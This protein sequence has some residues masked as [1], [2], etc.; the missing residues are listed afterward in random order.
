[1]DENT[2]LIDRLKRELADIDYNAQ[3]ASPNAPDLLESSFVEFHGPDGLAKL[4]RIEYAASQ[5]GS[6]NRSRILDMLI[7]LLEK[8][9]DS[10][11]G[12]T[13]EADD[14]TTDQ[15]AAYLAAQDAQTAGQPQ[16]AD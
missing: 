13:G 4:L 8:C 10:S 9:G 2:V 1:V 5:Q 3:N 6:A 14:E 15:I 7:R 16:S 12:G 11:P